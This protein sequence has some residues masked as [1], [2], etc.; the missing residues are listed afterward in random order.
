M[1]IFIMNGKT[2]LTTYI[3][4][5]PKKVLKTQFVIVSSTIRKLGKKCWDR[6]I[7]NANANLYPSQSLIMEYDDYK[8]DKNY[9]AEYY[10]QLDNSRALLATL[11][12]YV[13]DENYTV[14]ILCGKKESKYNYLNLIKKYVLDEFGFP[15]YDY[16]K[17]KEGKERIVQV[18]NYEITHRCNKVLKK[19]AKRKKEKMLSTEKG[20]KQYFSSMSKS[21]LKKELKK[22]DLYYPDMSKSEMID[23]LETFV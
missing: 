16:K 8:H 5:D 18:D 20:R 12:K 9:E 15:I 10:N 21:E 1:A 19:A 4:E 14:V 6:Q 23:M 11:I 7:I 17:F 22:R 13:V 3:K 2:F